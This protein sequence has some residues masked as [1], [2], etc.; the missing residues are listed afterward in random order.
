MPQII[1]KQS[2]KSSLWQQLLLY[3]SIVLLLG[4]I[5][6]YFIF[7]NIIQEKE[8]KLSQLEGELQKKE[9]PA[10]LALEKELSLLQKKIKDFSYIL[11]NHT[12]PSNLL[13]LLQETTY[14]KA[15]FNKFQFD[16]ATRQVSLT[17]KADSFESLSQQIFLLKEEKSFKKVNLNTVSLTEEGKVAFNLS[18]GVTPKV[19]K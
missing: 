8:T 12:K 2:Q 10:N 13:G 1:P 15:A 5:V 9:N 7:N 6:G 17:G 18:L 3:F 16:S 19:L 4:S 11:E 14:P